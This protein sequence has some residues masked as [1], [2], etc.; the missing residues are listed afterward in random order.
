MGSPSQRSLSKTLAVAVG[1]CLAT[2]VADEA[3]AA[4]CKL[5]AWV[6]L[7]S[8]QDLTS[9]YPAKALHDG[10]EGQATLRCTTEADGRLADCSVGA[11]SPPGYG[12]G[13]AALKLADKFRAEPP[14]PGAGE[15]KPGGREV[16]IRFAVAAYLPPHREAVFKHDS[17]K[18]AA[19]DPA[20]PFWPDMALRA[21]EAGS[22]TVQCV[23]LASGKLTD[24][25]VV[26][27]S[28]RGFGFGQAALRM[29]QRGWMTAAPLPP[30][31]PKGENAWTF[32]VTFPAK[33]LKDRAPGS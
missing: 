22:A 9:V 15:T 13:A 19:L 11:E 20:G 32:D 5:S 23:A 29:A 28:P 8:A 33:S 25:E 31:A 6:K 10:V 21:G 14:C 1:A 4:S 24:C 17:G 3:Q 27:E 7:P 2:A 30:D 26:Q 18:Y 12:F 16:P